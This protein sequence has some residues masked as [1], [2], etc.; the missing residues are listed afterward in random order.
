MSVINFVQLDPRMLSH[1]LIIN[2]PYHGFKTR[3][4]LLPAPIFYFEERT[5]FHGQR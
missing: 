4:L 1:R 3:K 5:P 2:K